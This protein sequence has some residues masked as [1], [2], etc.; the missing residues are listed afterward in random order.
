MSIDLSIYFPVSLNAYNMNFW[1]NLSKM[2]RLLR[3]VG[4]C[5]FK[6]S[7]QTCRQQHLTHSIVSVLA[8][9]LLSYYWLLSLDFSNK[10]AKVYSSILAVSQHINA[11]LIIISFSGLLYSSKRYAVQH[12]NILYQ[13][14]DFRDKLVILWPQIK[15]VSSNKVFMWTITNIFIYEILVIIGLTVWIKRV[16]YSVVNCRWNLLCVH[17]CIRGSI[18]LH[19]ICIVNFSFTLSAS[20]NFVRIGHERHS[21]IIEFGACISINRR[22]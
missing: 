13:V 7:K 20:D 22:T 21:T 10:D 2:Y 4:L 1:S 11:L 12:E 18:A 8:H 19:S 17:L 9:A 3:I 14:S 6:I 16:D 5:S 15:H